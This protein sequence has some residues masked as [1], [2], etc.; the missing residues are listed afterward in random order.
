M[1][2]S[3]PRE[4]FE[5]ELPALVQGDPTKVKGFNGTLLFTIKGERGGSWTVNIHDLQLDVKSEA[6]ANPDITITIKDGDFVDFI[7]RKL[8]GEIAFTTGKLKV[9]GDI[10]LAM[11]LQ[12]LLV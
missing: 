3:E 2:I 11:K 9:K 10:Q 5:R 8:S 12:G 1:Q 4:W 6:G 7:N